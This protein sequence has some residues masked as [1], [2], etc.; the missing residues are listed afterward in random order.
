MVVAIVA[1]IVALGGTGYAAVKL[2]SNSVGAKHI[3]R[4][5]VRSSEVKDRS[6]LKKDFKDGQLPAGPTGAAGAPG[7]AGAA[8]PPG[9]P[10]PEGAPGPPGPPGERGEEGEKGDEGEPGPATGPAGGALTGSYPNPQLRAHGAIVTTDT[11]QLI[12]D[13]LEQYV[14]WPI[15]RYDPDGL[16]TATQSQVVV[17]RDGLWQVEGFVVWQANGAGLRRLTLWGGNDALA[18]DTRPAPPFEFGHTISTTMLLEAGDLVLLAAHQTSGGNLNI[19]P[20][21][22]EGPS[23]SVMYL[24]EPG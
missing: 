4:A 9:P 16:H 12:G 22:T 7:L 5:A 6:L 13:G 14:Q 17:D 10:G 8:G 15:E 18:R 24:G 21:G 1:L 23:L 11:D 19:V 20:G 2:K 3:K